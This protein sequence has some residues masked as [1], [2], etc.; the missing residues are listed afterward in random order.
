M[1]TKPE[2]LDAGLA[3]LRHG[4]PLTLDAV[5]RRAGLTKPGVVHHFPTKAALAVAVVDRLVD[6][7]IADLES[8][9]GETSSTP[10]DRLRAYVDFAL[11][12]DLDPSDLALLSDVRLCDRLVRQW[13]D[14][15]HPWF[16]EELTS[17]P[18]GR[19]A[20]HAV[21]LIADG[22]WFDRALGIVDLDEDERTRIIDVAHRLVDEAVAA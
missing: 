6:R 4:E 15:L 10:Q 7:W 2:I 22:A 21:R 17:S 5:A 1:T 13:T 8:R 16:G 14:R 19:A 9:A 18:R 3:A 11:T 20:L 12:A